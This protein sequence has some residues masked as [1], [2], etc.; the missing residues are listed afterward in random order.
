VVIGLQK[1]NLKH[2]FCADLA[3]IRRLPK[4]G[5]NQRYSSESHFQLEL[6]LFLFGLGVPASCLNGNTGQNPPFLP[7]GNRR[8]LQ[9]R[10]R[11]VQSTPCARSRLSRI[12]LRRAAASSGPQCCD[13]DQPSTRASSFSLLC[14][15]TLIIRVACD[16]RNSTLRPWHMLQKKKGS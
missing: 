7:L 4:L 13:N 12:N 2:E 5:W 15:P 9:N 3:A 1:N 6:I 16:G 8:R 10:V 14:H 11:Y